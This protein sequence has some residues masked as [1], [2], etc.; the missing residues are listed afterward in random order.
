MN[1]GSTAQ[2][3]NEAWD[4]GKQHRISEGLLLPLLRNLRLEFLRQGQ[5]FSTSR[6]LP[7]ASHNIV[8]LRVREL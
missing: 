2:S 5:A 6:A 4:S 8:E 7:Q 3:L 1:L